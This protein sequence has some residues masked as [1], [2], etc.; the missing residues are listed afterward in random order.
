MSCWS[1][2]PDEKESQRSVF[3]EECSQHSM[4]DVEGCLGEEVCELY[5]FSSSSV[6]I[7]KADLDSLNTAQSKQKNQLNLIA[8]GGTDALL[9]SLKVSAEKGLSSPRVKYMRRIF[10]SNEFPTAPVDSYLS[11]VTR[12]LGD[13]TMVSLCLQPRR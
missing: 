9:A 8:I 7:T 6:S 12:A 3:H 4:R 5:S 11:L 2:I 13:T 1:K 10:G